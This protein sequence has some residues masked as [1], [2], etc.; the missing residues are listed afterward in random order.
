[1]KRCP[2]CEFIYEDEQSLCDMDGIALVTSSEA[3]TLT[4]IAALE[5]VPPATRSPKS[6]AWR[7]LVTAVA[8]IVLGLV[9]ILIYSVFNQRGRMRVA[10]ASPSQVV[11]EWQSPSAGSSSGKPPAR[12]LDSSPSTEPPT[13]PEVRDSAEQDQLAISDTA[14]GTK[15]APSIP[16]TF[17]PGSEAKSKPVSFSPKSRSVNQKAVENTNPKKGSTIGSI[18]R[19]AGRILKK[20]FTR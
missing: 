18:L 10:S 2:Q 14:A 11:A 7:F 19:K 8:S 3:L 5:P 4:G 13:S 15:P 1:M 12:S 16:Q 17:T 6:R 9:L 20:P